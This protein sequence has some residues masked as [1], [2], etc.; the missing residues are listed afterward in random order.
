MANKHVRKLVNKSE[1][2]RIAGVAQPSVSRAT[3]KKLKPAL[4]GN[5][6]DLNHPAVIK[7][8]ADQQPAEHGPARGIDPLY[9]NAVDHCQST[10]NFT[11]SSVSRG[12]RIGY[13]R[14]GRI[15]KMMQAAGTDKSLP[16][17]PPPRTLRDKK[18][19]LLDKKIQKKKQKSLNKL[20]VEIDPMDV[21]TIIH[22]IPD[23]IATFAHMTLTELIQR[24]GTDVA[25]VDWLRAT[26]SI[27][28]IN[29]KR[30]KNAVTQG[31]LVS[32]KLVKLGVI[33]RIN[34]AHQ[35]LL[36]DG[37]KTIN[38]RVRAMTQG[39]RSEK[40]TEKF[41]VDQMSSFIKPMKI[42]MIKS[43]KRI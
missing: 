30:L 14:A 40:E 15:F 18:K 41:I 8:I 7:Y 28:D 11:I 27:E 12:L 43:L 19:P 26:K 32:R 13:Q 6:I 33:D 16:P 39:S 36:T 24:F 21:G 1:L 35:K 29:E 23:D 31:D 38:I 5:K 17:L 34:A 4:V 10:N 20:T 9:Q 3:T 37:A 25:F 42:K 2:A 22:D